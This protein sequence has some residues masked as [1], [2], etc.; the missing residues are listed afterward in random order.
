MVL[1]RIALLAVVFLLAFTG[2]LM[3]AE[4]KPAPVAT[5]QAAICVYGDVY[6]TGSL[7][8]RGIVC[9]GQTQYAWQ[10]CVSPPNPP[11]TIV[12]CDEADQE[13][14]AICVYGDAY[15]TG[16]RPCQG[17]VCIGY[18]MGRWVDCYPRFPPCWAC[19]PPPAT[20]KVA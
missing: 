14:V 11:C 3:S 7:P 15:N 1:S 20:A 2:T 8:C 19:P 18:T 13:Q 5:D 4:A 12:R 17:A 6:N 10:N 16:G 9:N